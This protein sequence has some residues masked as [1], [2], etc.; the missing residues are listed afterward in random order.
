MQ[1]A[2]DWFGRIF[3]AQ[4]KACDA[5]L[6]VDGR[7]RRSKR[8]LRW[9]DRPRGGIF[10][11]LLEYS[12]I[13]ETAMR[14]LIV[15][16]VFSILGMVAASQAQDIGD[17]QQGRQL[18]LDVCASCHA[19]RAGQTQSPLATAPSFKE[20]AHMPG[21]TAAALAFWLTAQSHPTM[22][23]LILSPQQVRNVSAY[24]LSLRD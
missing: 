14:T 3:A 17:V 9:H 4:G 7:E 6:P 11:I 5:Q 19:V 22:P 10:C 24:L 20:I 1:P 15:S 21:M 18:A 8:A 23:N 16:A 13:E 2:G 12:V